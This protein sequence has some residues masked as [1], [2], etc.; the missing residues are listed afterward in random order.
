MKINS[1]D[2]FQAI[3]TAIKNVRWRDC[4]ENDDFEWYYAE[5]RHYAIHRK[6]TNAYWFVKSGNPMSAYETVMSNLKKV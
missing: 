1:D 6:S 4:E 3:F 2:A 5:D